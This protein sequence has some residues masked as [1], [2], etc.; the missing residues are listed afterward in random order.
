MPDVEARED[1]PPRPSSCSAGVAAIRSVIVSP[2]TDHSRLLPTLAVVVPETSPFH[3]VRGDD[4]AFVIENILWTKKTINKAITTAIVP[5]IIFSVFWFIK[6]RVGAI[7][8]NKKDKRTGHNSYYENP[9]DKLRKMLRN[10]FGH[11]EHVDY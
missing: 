10:K 5:T 6:S 7:K 2:G 1:M 3:V 8:T 9:I 11:F 4:S